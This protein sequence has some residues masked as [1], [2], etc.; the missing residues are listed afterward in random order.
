M[1]EILKMCFL[2]YEQ[3]KH[4]IWEFLSVLL[5]LYEYFVFETQELAS[6]LGTWPP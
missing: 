4:K 2:E 5:I 3:H 1:R 6:L